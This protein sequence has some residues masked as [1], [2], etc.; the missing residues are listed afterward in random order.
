MTLEDFYNTWYLSEYLWIYRYIN[1]SNTSYPKSSLKQNLQ[2]ERESIFSSLI[3]PDDEIHEKRN[4]QQQKYPSQRPT[5]R[6]E[7]KKKDK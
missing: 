4:K 1:K 3:V 7:N 6:T 5:K 2:P